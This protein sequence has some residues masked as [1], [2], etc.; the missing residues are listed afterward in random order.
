[1][2]KAAANCGCADGLVEGGDW[3]SWKELDGLMRQGRTNN[4]FSVRRDLTRAVSGRWRVGAA[5]DFKLDWF[6]QFRTLG[7][8]FVE[9]A[10]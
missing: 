5:R 8:C 9:G 4:E 2:W 1:M 7:W 6:N 3:H 10:A